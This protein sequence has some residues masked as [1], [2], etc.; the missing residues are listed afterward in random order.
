MEAIAQFAKEG[1]CQLS[2]NKYKV[3]GGEEKAEEEVEFE[4]P[5]DQQLAKSLRLDIL[6]I[7]P[8][9]FEQHGRTPEGRGRSGEFIYMASVCALSIS[10]LECYSLAIYNQQQGV[11]TFL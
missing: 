9:I 2:L 3:H 8:S 5:A 1:Q 10:A 4:P 6:S 7:L 11:I